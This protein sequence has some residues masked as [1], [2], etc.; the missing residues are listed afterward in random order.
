MY[1]AW[2]INFYNTIPTKVKSSLK[3]AKEKLVKLVEDF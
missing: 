1:Y 2:S 3:N